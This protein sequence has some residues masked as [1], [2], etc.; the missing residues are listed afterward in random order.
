MGPGRGV[1]P[2]GCGRLRGRLGPG[3]GPALATARRT[4]GAERA[5]RG[6]G[7]AAAALTGPGSAQPPPRPAHR[8]P[9]P[10]PSAGG[11]GPARPGPRHRSV[12]RGPALP[13]H[14]GYCRH[15]SGSSGL[16]AEGGPAEPEL[17]EAVDGSAQG[18]AVLRARC[19]SS[20]SPCWGQRFHRH[21]LGLWSE[22]RL[23]GGSTLLFPSRSC[24]SLSGGVRHSLTPLDSPPARGIRPGVAQQSTAKRLALPSHKAGHRIIESSLQW[25]DCL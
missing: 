7:R 12:R 20:R 4:A 25:P 15:G 13:G 17:R 18:P 2:G 19:R 21:C 1:G 5:E 3:S 23:G 14:Q 22:S 10:P 6:A 9:A 8:G 24:R 11:A 16:A